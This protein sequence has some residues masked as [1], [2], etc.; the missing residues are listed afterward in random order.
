MEIIGKILFIWEQELV[1]ANQLPKQTIVLEEVEGWK[2]PNT[3]AIEFFKDKIELLN[4]LNVGDIVT[5]D[6]NTKANESKT[7]PG[8]WF[9]SISAW[10]LNKNQWADYSQVKEEI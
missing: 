3:L 7:Q 5:V 2:Y 10:K 8:R 1:G 4:G 9:N 6:Y